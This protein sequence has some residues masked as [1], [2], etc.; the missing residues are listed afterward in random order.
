MKLMIENKTNLKDVVDEVFSVVSRR[1][2]GVS[3][4]L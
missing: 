1:F 2:T 3:R 4:I